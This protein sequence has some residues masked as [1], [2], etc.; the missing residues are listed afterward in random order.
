MIPMKGQEEKGEGEGEGEGEQ[1][2][3]A[4]GGF[5]YRRCG[6]EVFVY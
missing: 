1:V 3:K 6:L 2:K 5:V 4:W